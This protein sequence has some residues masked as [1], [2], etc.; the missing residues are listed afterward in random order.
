MMA[1]SRFWEIIDVSRQQAKT[2]SRDPSVDF[3]DLHEKT[4][5]D[6]RWALAPD[7]IIAFDQ[8][9]W[10]YHGIAYR[11]DLWMLRIGWEAV[12]A[13]TALSIFDPV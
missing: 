4:L 7:E 1:E 2:V 6:Q 3:M 11:W 5:A 12:A 10:N 9:F 13:T 8:R